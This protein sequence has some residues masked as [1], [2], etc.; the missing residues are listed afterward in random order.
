VLKSWRSGCAFSDQ[1]IALAIFYLINLRDQITWFAVPN[2]HKGFRVDN[3]QVH[4]D[5]PDDIYNVLVLIILRSQTR[6]ETLTRLFD[7]DY[8]L[9]IGGLQTGMQIRFLILYFWLNFD[10]LKRPIILVYLIMVILNGQLTVLILLLVK[11]M[12]II[13]RLSKDEGLTVFKLAHM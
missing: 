10:H 1:N 11:M 8:K 4:A 7:G 2:H 5:I 3:P 9:D 12:I 13:I 6:L